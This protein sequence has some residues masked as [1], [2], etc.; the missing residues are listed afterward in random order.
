MA[1]EPTMAVAKMAA[2]AAAAGGS[3]RIAIAMHGGSRG[4]R[5][6]IEGFVGATL[7]VMAA[8]IAVWVDPSLRDAGWPLLIVAGAAGIAG[9]LGT[10]ALDLLEAALRKRVT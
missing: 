10:R 2:A 8:G 7:G 9:A 3:A 4:W 6:A 1:E 5:L